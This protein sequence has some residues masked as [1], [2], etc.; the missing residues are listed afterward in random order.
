MDTVSRSNE[1]YALPAFLILTPLLSLA[2]P[3]FVSL[4]PEITPLMIAIIPAILSIVLTA[5]TNGGR[6]VRA[7]LKKPFEWRVGFK[8]YVVALG[9]ALGLRLTMSVLALLLGWIP[10]IQIRAWSLPQFILLG[11][12]ILVG[13]AAEELGWR[14]YVLPRLLTSRS[15]LFSALLL[16]IIWGVLHL[17]LT[18]PG[19]MN[20]GSHWLPTILQ[21]IGLSVVLTWLY[22]QTGGNIVIP[23]V[24]HAG[25][26]ILVF[27]NE[28]ISLTEQLWLLTVVTLAYSLVIFFFLGA[29]MRRGR[30]D[31]PAMVNVKPVETK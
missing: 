5:L 20:A 8:W 22:I 9:L 11:T 28:G 16:G 7:L 19:Q 2:I 24:F 10:A 14:G 13:S 1:R 4:P 3:L 26:N 29:N 12:F 23:I 17:S 21:I 15:A 31:E 25:Q 18:F 6:G 30:T 27:L